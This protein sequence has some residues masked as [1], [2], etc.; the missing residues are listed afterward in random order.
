MKRPSLSALWQE[1]KSFAFKGNM[2]DLAVAVVIGAAFSGVINSLVKDVIMPTVT[3]AVTTAT[4]AATTAGN[5]IKETATKAT[6][7][8]GL[9][10][11]PAESQPADTQPVA[12][13]MPVPPPP[14]RA[15]HRAGK[16]RR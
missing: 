1:F 15:C 10:T 14:A 11:K 16:A 13:A 2:I 9:T 12:A 7:S 4:T 6:E 8:V 5:A 3:Y